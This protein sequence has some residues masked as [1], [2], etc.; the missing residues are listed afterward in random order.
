MK[1]YNDRSC[2][3][4]CE[5]SKSSCAKTYIRWQ[6]DAYE[7]SLI[8]PFWHLSIHIGSSHASHLYLHL[9]ACHIIFVCVCKYIYAF[10]HIYVCVIIQNMWTF[11]HAFAPHT[12]IDIIM[13]TH[14]S[15]CTCTRTY[16]AT[17]THIYTHAHAHIHIHNGGRP[18]RDLSSTSQPSSAPSQRCAQDTMPWLVSSVPGLVSLRPG[19]YVSLLYVY[20]WYVSMRLYVYMY[21]FMHVIFVRKSTY[22]SARRPCTCAPPRAWKHI[23]ISLLPLSTIRIHASPQILE[24]MVT[25]HICFSCMIFVVLF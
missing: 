13:N 17:R 12:Y 4:R 23:V 22:A 5:V 9:H 2:T 11:V 20:V 7:H 10:E 6:I 14:T 19:S 3:K 1:K 24:Y 8:T 25:S 15:R 18:C 16:T 21:A